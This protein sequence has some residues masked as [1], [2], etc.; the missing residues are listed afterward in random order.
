MKKLTLQKPQTVADSSSSP[1]PEKP[2][3][4]ILQ[5]DM[6]WLQDRY[7]R[8]SDLIYRQFTV[9][10][11]HGRQ[12][13]VFYID[14]MTS[15]KVVHDNI[16][17]PLLIDAEIAKYDAE[18]EQENYFSFVKQHLLP[19]GEITTADDLEQGS[20]A[21]MNGDVLLLL[22]GCRQGFIIDAKGFPH[23]S[24]GTSQNEMCCAVRRKRLQKRCG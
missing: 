5:Q 20:L 17:Q 16:L 8:C 13:V 14:G 1:Q 11:Q 9:G 2:F 6:T 21:M 15:S 4:G 23:R 3:T 18:N 22:D 19:A 12:A 7:V 10:G 24:I